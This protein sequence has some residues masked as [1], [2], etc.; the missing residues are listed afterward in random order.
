MNPPSFFPVTVQGARRLINLALVEEIFEN[1]EGVTCVE[2]ASG[3]VEIDQCIDDIL[4]TLK[5]SVLDEC[6]RLRAENDRLQRAY[7]RPDD[8]REQLE[9]AQSEL[10]R[11]RA[12][13]SRLQSDVAR[14][15]C[16]VISR[17]IDGGEAWFWQ[18]DGGDHLES[19]TCPVIIRPEQLRTMVEALARV[20]SIGE[21]FV[22]PSDWDTPGMGGPPPIDAYERVD[23]S[24][25]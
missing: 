10:T 5:S 6:L 16:R 24:A 11:L 21:V 23:L 14:K 1:A 13:V 19:L 12:E 4:R 22:P 15:D 25:I 17:R 18:G 8:L 9:T 20:R 2:F 3:G 7:V